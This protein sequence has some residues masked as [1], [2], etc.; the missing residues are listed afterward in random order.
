[1]SAVAAPLLE[2]RDLV[3]RYPLRHANRT[4]AQDGSAGES[5]VAV[6]GVSMSIGAG[7]ILALVG[8]SG[9]GKTSLARAVLQLVDVGHGRGAAKEDVRRMVRPFDTRLRA[10]QVRVGDCAD[11]PGRHRWHAPHRARLD[12]QPRHRLVF[13]WFPGQEHRR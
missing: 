6:N 8:E 11:G 2:L 5:L 1:M 3:V 4:R 7:R 10:E 9:S 13:Y 12:L